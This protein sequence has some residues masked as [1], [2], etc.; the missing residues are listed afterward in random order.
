MPL[1]EPDPRL[2]GN[3]HAE[4]RKEDGGAMLGTAAPGHHTTTT[5]AATGASGD[6]QTIAMSTSCKGCIVLSKSLE[7][8]RERVRV[9]ERLLDHSENPLLVATTTQQS[10]PKAEVGATAED[11]DSA[12]PMDQRDEGQDTSRPGGTDQQ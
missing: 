11:G 7:D 5:T 6:R 1:E 9:Q 10:G 12:T 2:V 8:L 3:Y 4:E